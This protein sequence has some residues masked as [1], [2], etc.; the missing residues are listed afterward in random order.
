MTSAS[1]SRRVSASPKPPPK[2]YTLPSPPAPATADVSSNFDISLK[3]KNEVPIV[4][5]N[6]WL[7]L[8]L[9]TAFE[10]EKNGI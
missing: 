3:Y 1:T 2:L 9:H 8:A 10:N 5:D 7:S 4:I 6:G